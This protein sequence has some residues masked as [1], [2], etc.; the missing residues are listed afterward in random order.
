MI[1]VPLSLLGAA[2]A[3]RDEILLPSHPEIYKLVY[4]LPAWSWQT[5][6]IIVACML[7]ALILESAYRAIRRRE[8]RYTELV[9]RYSHALVLQNVVPQTDWKNVANMLELRLLL[10]NSTSLPLKFL[11]QD[12]RLA[13]NGVVIRQAN[14]SSSVMGSNAQMTYFPNRGLSKLQFDQVPER[15]VGTLVYEI[16][17]GH[18]DLGYSR[19]V[20]KELRVELFKNRKTRQVSLIQTVLTEKDSPIGEV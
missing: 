6:L 11:V 14:S 17:Y 12:Y 20:T 10:Q 15:C 3:V 8:D 16:A 1:A 9:D 19:L 2:G 13:F 5:Y 4:W 7:L 18:P